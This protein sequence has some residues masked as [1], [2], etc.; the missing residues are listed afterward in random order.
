MTDEKWEKIAQKRV[1]N[2]TSE[3]IPTFFIGPYCVRIFQSSPTMI[4]V[5]IH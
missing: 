2:A 1:K 3:K 5:G 4:N